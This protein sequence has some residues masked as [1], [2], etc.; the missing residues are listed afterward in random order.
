MVRNVTGAGPLSIGSSVH[1]PPTDAR[2]PVIMTTESGRTRHLPVSTYLDIVS[3]SSGNNL[4][5][6]AEGRGTVA[7][8][9][10]T[11]VGGGHGCVPTGSITRHHPVQLSQPPRIF[12]KAS[13]EQG[14]SPFLKR[15]RRL[16]RV[17]KLAVDLFC[18]F[19]A[20]GK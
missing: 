7:G 1:S 15:A 4:V 16:V 8:Q 2:S 10:E 11:M 5:S 14:G 13:Y 3:A 19:L 12:R 18:F 9:Q 17:L 6:R 20:G